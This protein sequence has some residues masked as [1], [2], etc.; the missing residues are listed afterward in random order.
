MP[1]HVDD[2][3]LQR[4]ILDGAGGADTFVG[5]GVRTNDAVHGSDHDDRSGCFSGDDLI[6]ESSSQQK[7]T[8]GVFEVFAEGLSGDVR[9]IERVSLL[10]VVD[11]DV[12]LTCGLDRCVETGVERVFVELV[13]LHSEM[14]CSA[15]RRKIVGDLLGAIFDSTGDDD[16]RARLGQRPRE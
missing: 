15:W 14:G 16:T 10:A 12:D 11:Q 5:V 13:E 7:V 1:R 4:V 8:G 6:P 3:A 2:A 9:Q